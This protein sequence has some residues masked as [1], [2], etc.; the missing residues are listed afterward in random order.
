[1]AGLPRTEDRSQVTLC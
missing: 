1:M